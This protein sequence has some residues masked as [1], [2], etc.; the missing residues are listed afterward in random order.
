VIDAA[1]PGQL[2]ADGQL[3][4]ALAAD[5]P[6]AGVI[7]ARRLP[8]AR[9][10]RAFTHVA[11]ESYP[12]RGQQMPM[13]FAVAVASDDPHAKHVAERLSRDVGFTPVDLGSLADSA[14]L[15]PGGVLWSPVTAGDLRARLSRAHRHPQ[16]QG[17]SQ[18]ANTRLCPAARTSQPALPWRHS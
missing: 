1:N 2:T 12:V 9:V 8:N 5:D 11:A 7:T 6:P 13:L 4:S 3:A 17:T 14:P 16:D 10:A 18:A 15:D